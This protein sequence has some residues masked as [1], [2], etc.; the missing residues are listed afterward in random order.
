MDL[1]TRG[2]GRLGALGKMRLWSG[3]YCMGVEYTKIII[4]KN[5]Y[6]KNHCF[7]RSN[8]DTDALICKSNIHTI[9]QW[10]YSSERLSSVLTCQSLERNLSS[11]AEL[12][13]DRCLLNE[14]AHAQMT[15]QQF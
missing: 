9:S 8:T 15:R 11:L 7:L 2:G 4:I 1:G 12:V 10:I 13:T 5:Y 3:M 14:C 6:L